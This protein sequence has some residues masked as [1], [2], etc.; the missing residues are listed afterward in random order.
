MDVSILFVDHLPHLL[1]RE[2]VESI[3]ITRP[4]LKWRHYISWGKSTVLLRR[5]TWS[6]RDED[7]QLESSYSKSKFVFETSFPWRGIY[8]PKK[9]NKKSRIF[10]QYLWSVMRE[11]EQ[12]G[13]NRTTRLKIYIKNV[14]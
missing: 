10:M 14:I 6:W 7:M 11:T 4:T 2:A 8:A 9:Q 1:S 5:N 3:I 13:E 12:T